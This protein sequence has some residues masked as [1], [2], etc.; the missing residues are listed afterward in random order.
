MTRTVQLDAGRVDVPQ[1]CMYDE[2]T[3][4]REGN[5][6]GLAAVEDSASAQVQRLGTALG[7]DQH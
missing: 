6:N 7:K 3:T 5:G 4:Y 1:Q 2:T